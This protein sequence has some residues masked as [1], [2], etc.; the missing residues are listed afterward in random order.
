M[1]AA[2]QADIER[3]VS[4]GLQLQVTLLT[5]DGERLLSVRHGD[6]LLGTIGSALDATCTQCFLGDVD[7]S[8]GSFADQDIEEGARLR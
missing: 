7:V 8:E 5:D 6:A 1:E 3:V 4:S 2:L